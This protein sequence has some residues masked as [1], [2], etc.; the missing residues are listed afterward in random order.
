MKRRLVHALLLVAVALVLAPASA[1]A[2]P[3]RVWH[4]Y[5]GDEEKAL[6]AVL[7]DWKGE[8]VDALSVPYD[9]YFTK[10]SAAIP[11]GDGPDLFIASH[12][13]LGEFRA[14]KIVGPVGDALEKGVFSESSIAAVTSDGQAWAVPLSQKCMALYVNTDL[15]PSVPTY[16]EDFAELVP[17]LPP[18]V[19]P[20]AY[21][22]KS[23]YGMAGLLHGFG[24]QILDESDQ[25]RFVGPEAER[26]VTFARWLIERRVMPED[27]DGA[28]VTNLFRSG[29]AAYA[30]SGPWLAGELG[31][32]P[33][34]RYRVA[35]LPKVKATGL[36]MRPLLT[37]ESIML[38][39]EGGKRAEVRALAKLLASAEA[40][41]IRAALGPTPSARLDVRAGEDGSIVRVFAQQA[42]T[43]VP[44]PS[45]RAM[46]GIWDPGERAIKKVLRG[47][48]GAD[49]ALSE[50]KHRFDDV[51][52]PLPPP[53]SPAP[54]LV[55]VGGLG[56]YAVLRWW[57]RAREERWGAGLRGSLPAYRYVI[58]AVLA[59]G[60][61]VI[62]PLSMG[63]ATSLFAG[64]DEARRYVGLQNFIEILTARGGPLFA[65]GSFYLVL[66]VTILWTAANLVLHV[67]IGVALALLLSRPTLRLRPLYRVLLIVPWAVPSY[68]TALVWKGMFQRQFGAVTGLIL[69]V[70]RLF[71]AHI[72]SIA[73]FSKFS[74]AFTANVTTNVWLGFPFM[75]V[76]TL[77]ALTAVPEDVLE[78]ARVDGATRFQRLVRVTL[79]IIRPTLAPAVTLG[80][81]WTFN[82]FNVVFLV[83][84]GE[85][86]GTTDI[87]VSEAYRWAF[88]RENQYGY[89][90]AYAVLIFVLLFAITRA[91]SRRPEKAVGPSSDASA[92]T[93]APSSETA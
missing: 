23:P 92:S 44:M 71:G 24:G 19:Y 83:S 68:I 2:A 34:L 75:M 79:P 25:Y 32:N 35:L 9:A 86:D 85:P 16:I 76:V 21:D 60:M 89:A 6:D 70:N 69:A 17:K 64:S 26:A 33:N 80:A 27:A 15:A 22:P 72:E 78:A 46:N 59:V 30:I 53:V 40:A 37:V 18:G 82:M 45:S 11:I 66:A 49:V 8:P 93:L 43:A 77:G 31:G 63:A 41:R 88:T 38:S 4:A 54:A 52:R 84:G 56:L 87:L 50:G 65:S 12:E 47:D 13:K 39:P 62:L 48:L 91:T 61:L 58:H 29:K 73:W 1:L 42:R 5:R 81:I 74:T 3:I 36:P 20:L 51:R 14:R 28:L 67:G 55:L 57:K 90:A 7:A 10:L